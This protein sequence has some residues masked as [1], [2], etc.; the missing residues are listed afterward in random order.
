MEV[1]IG[2]EDIDMYAD[3]I[4]HLG[5]DYYFSSMKTKT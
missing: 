2:A 1:E 4:F 5:W 3:L